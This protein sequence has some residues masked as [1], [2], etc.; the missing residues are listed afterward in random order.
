MSLVLAAVVGG[1]AVIAYAM[2]AG[3]GDRKVGTVPSAKVVTEPAPSDTG[4]DAR[5]AATPSADGAVDAARGD[6]S[7][8]DATA[9]DGSPE[10][11]SHRCTLGD[12]ASPRPRPP[13]RRRRRPHRTRETRR[14]PAI[15]L[16]PSTK[17]VSRPEAGVHPMK[18]AEPET[19]VASGTR[20]RSTSSTTIAS[21]T[22]RG[23]ATS[24]PVSRPGCRLARTR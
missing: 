14:L 1:L 11:P 4:I 7:T 17:R 21:A 6:G 15:H 8:R 20:S 9:R 5:A 13:S 3:D 18:A 16:S 23:A 22:I 19:E 10:A 2:V 24:P 12:H